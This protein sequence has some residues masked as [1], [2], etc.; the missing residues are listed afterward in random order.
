MALP[1][2]A[3]FDL[4]A[5]LGIPALTAHRCLTVGAEGPDAVS[6][7]T[8]SGQTVLV[9]GGAGAV[10]HATIELA[11]WAGATVVTTV[12]S[13]EKAVLAKAAGADHV[14]DYRAG[15]AIAAIRGFAADG[16]NLIVEVSPIANEQLDQAVV[17][18]NGTVAIYSTGDR[19]LAV[20]VRP[21]MLNNIRYQFVLVY[22]VPPRAKQ[23]AVRDVVAAVA[24]GAL[25]AGPD[26]GLPLLRYPLAE[27][28]A[29]HEAVENQAVGKVL[30][31]VS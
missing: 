20:D 1:D 21:L 18:P 28:A 2:G 26:A 7:G 12:S 4:G 29:A 11:K 31:D 14:V 10:G 8:L 17:A 9:S 27:T 22:T 15:D 19:D 16:V 5:T 6:P 30:V 24:A 3:S 25:R 13:P 23:Q